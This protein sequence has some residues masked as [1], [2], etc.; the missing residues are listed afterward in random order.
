MDSGAGAEG[1]REPPPHAPRRHLDVRPLLAAGT[2]PFDAIMGAVD[3]LAD[4]EALVLRSPF[5]PKPLHRVLGGRGYLHQPRELAPG[6][7]ETTYWQPQADPAPQPLVLD[8]RGLQ[9]PEPM[10]RTLAGLE[11]LPAGATLVQINERVPVFLLELLEERGHRY[12]VGTDERGTII[13]ITAGG[14][15]A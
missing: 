15:G 4:G 7:W 12:E 8:V 13:T 6:D 14:A 11:G 5:D 1:T 2:E 10:E 3:G 9:P